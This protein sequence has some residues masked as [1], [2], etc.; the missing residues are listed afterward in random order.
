[1]SKI[2]SFFRLNIAFV[3]LAAVILDTAYL[4]PSH[5]KRWR[6][7]NVNAHM[8]GSCRDTACVFVCLQTLRMKWKHLGGRGSSCAR[9][10][11]TAD[12]SGQTRRCRGGRW[13]DSFLFPS[14]LTR[15]SFQ[16][17]QQLRVK[18][19]PPLKDSS[20]KRGS[21]HMFSYHI[22]PL[23]PPSGTFRGVFKKSVSLRKVPN[24]VKYR[25]V[26]FSEH[27]RYSSTS[28]L[29]WGQGK[30]GRGQILD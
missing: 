26:R 13:C 2:R 4:Q 3:P 22:I 11:G 25:S 1:M 27:H 20:L 18:M 9:R 10:S 19:H 12:G 29:H 14:S 7:M 17:P 16:R 6:R 30:G 23:A 5:L 8:L 24:W 21:R 28:W 15:L